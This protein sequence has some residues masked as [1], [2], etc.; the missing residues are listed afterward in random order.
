MT[1]VGWRKI[2]DDH[3]SIEN[4]FDFHK[5]SSFCPP[6]CRSRRSVVK[7]KNSAAATACKTR[8]VS[9]VFK[10]TS[11]AQCLILIA[12]LQVNL[13]IVYLTTSCNKN[14][15]FLSESKNTEAIK[16]KNP[17]FS[18]K[19]GPMFLYLNE[20]FQN[21]KVTKEAILSTVHC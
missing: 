3:Y 20:F 19:E 12:R 15:V 11:T 5:I 8:F 7:K 10:Y 18:H 4:R 16:C 6:Q 17:R 13:G 2:D 21:H 1:E 9:F 14:W